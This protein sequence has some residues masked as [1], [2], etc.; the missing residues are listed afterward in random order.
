M[1]RY[2]PEPGAIEN[3]KRVTGEAFFQPA[4]EAGWI[5]LGNV[6]MHKNAPEVSRKIVKRSGRGGFVF[7]AR[8]DVTEASAIY[9]VQLNEHTIENVELLLFGL[10]LD[11]YEQAGM[12]GQVV[13]INGV[14]KRRLYE[15]G[16]YDLSN[17]AVAAGLVAYVEGRDYRLDA[18]AG[19]IYI[20]DG[21][22]IGAGADLTVTF[23]A[24]PMRMDR[25]SATARVQ[26]EGLFRIL[27]SDN[28]SED[29]RT[30]ITFPCALSA[31]SQGEEQPDD[32]N[33][34][35][36]RVVATGQPDVRLRTMPEPRLIVG[37]EMLTIGDPFELLGSLDIHAGGELLVA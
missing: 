22:M 23:D 27:E 26:R 18:Q 37:G 2:S 16:S 20:I 12:A 15:T 17:I 14:Q 33:Q 11:D 25:I 9:S 10:R 6:V 21:G 7:A 30:I 35:T 24:A 19:T 13:A 3:F 31:E 28:Q 36:L 8:E 34:F 29:L 4:G 5:N 32:I 1:S